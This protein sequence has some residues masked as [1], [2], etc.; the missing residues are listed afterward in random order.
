M[1]WYGSI[2]PRIHPYLFRNATI[3]TRVESLLEIAP[4]YG[5]WTQFLLAYAARMVV[6]DL[7]EACI[8]ACQQRFRAADHI[9]YH[10]NDGKSLAMIAADSIDFA[11][12]YDSLVHVESD[13][14]EAYLAELSRVLR[15]G[16][17]AF[18]HH[19]NLGQYSGVVAAENIKTHWR[20]RTVSAESV[21]TA[22][23]RA[24]LVCVSQ[25]LVNWDGG[26]HHIDCYS[27]FR[28]LEGERPDVVK[29][30]VSDFSRETAYVRS[31]AALYV[32]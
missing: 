27:V 30:A 14:I 2:L 6:V 10:V 15:I 1:H 25:E 7:N 29:T 8:T 24:G 20:G 28:K 12:S 3:P 5:R 23:S 21:R 32:E 22:A 11:F 9:T 17:S 19:S 4:G 26:E 13:V 31:L 18:I 16:G